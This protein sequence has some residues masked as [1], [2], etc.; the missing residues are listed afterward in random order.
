MT[1]LEDIDFLLPKE[2]QQILRCS[3]TEANYICKSIKHHRIGKMIRVNKTDF[4][5][6]LKQCESKN[7]IHP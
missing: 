5:Q 6:F 4:M 1:P 3:K 2:I 7:H